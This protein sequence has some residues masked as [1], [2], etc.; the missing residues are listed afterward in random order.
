[1]ETKQQLELTIR[2]ATLIKSV[3]QLVSVHDAMIAR[4]MFHECIEQFT[5]LGKFVDSIQPA[6]RRRPE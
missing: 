2:T 1:M 6:Q 5:A 4:L 3:S